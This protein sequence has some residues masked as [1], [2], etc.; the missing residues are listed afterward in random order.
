MD[1]QPGNNPSQPPH[2]Q[3]SHEY[4]GPPPQQHQDLY[5]YPPQQGF[6]QPGSPQQGFPQQPPQ[7]PLPSTARDVLLWAGVG[8]AICGFLGFIIGFMGAASAETGDGGAVLAVSILFCALGAFIGAA[9]GAGVGALVHASKANSH[10]AAHGFIPQ[11]PQPGFTPTPMQPQYPPQQ[12]YSQ[13]PFPV[14]PTL[15]QQF[16]PHQNGH[17]PP[18]R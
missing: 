2:T 5:F 10:R 8:A 14:E 9:I 12:Q 18:T 15:P 11:G 13:Q 7:Q 3:N 6:P 4:G 17:E 16:P 1:P